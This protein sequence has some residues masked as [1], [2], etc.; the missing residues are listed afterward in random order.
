MIRKSEVVK[1]ALYATEFYPKQK[2]MIKAINYAFHKKYFSVCVEYKQKISELRFDFCENIY[3][4]ENKDFPFYCIVFDKYKNNIFYITDE[5]LEI[6]EFVLGD[7][8]LVEYLTELDY[9][10]ILF[11]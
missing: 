3:F 9:K 11:R 1:R 7:I 2:R 6:F 10:I 4:H 5:N 8:N